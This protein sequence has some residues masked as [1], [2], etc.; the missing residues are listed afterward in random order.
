MNLR[1]LDLID[2]LVVA[3]AIYYLLVWLR[4]T[5]AMSLIRGLAVILLLYLTG[6]I[7]GLYTISWLLERLGPLILV[8]IIIIFQPELRRTLEHIG[9]ERIFLKLGMAGGGRGALIVGHIIK[10]IEQLSEIKTGALIVFERST[11]LSEFLESGVGLD[12]GISAELIISIFSSGNPLHD[13]A[14]IIQGER[15]A[16]AG[17]L[18]PLSDT[19]LLDRRLGTRHR[20][21]VGM[22]EQTD[23]LVFI[24]S[25]KTGIISIAENGYLSRNISKEMLEEKL[26]DLYKARPSKKEWFGLRGAAKKI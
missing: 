5:R 22:S 26:F 6:K 13:G 11:G 25:E 7:F 8:I 20:A 19:K 16:A 14:V 24:V 17:C 4:G 3:V 21:A 15:I 12:A 10:A 2:I 18:L 9:R 1:I 23:A